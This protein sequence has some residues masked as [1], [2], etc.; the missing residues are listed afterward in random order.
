[1]PRIDGWLSVVRDAVLGLLLV[2]V[3]WLTAAPADAA[4]RG[5]QL[6]FAAVS[7][8]AVLLRRRWPASAVAAALAA[9]CAAWALGMTY[10]PFVLAGWCVLVL[11]EQRGTRAVPWWMVASGAVLLVVTLALGADGIEDRLRGALLGAV[12]L[13]AAW[14]LGV[15][16]REAL[17]EAAERSRSEERLRLAR[18]VHDVLSHS[19]GA[20]G[21]RAGVTAHVATL[22]EEDLRGA[23]RE[24]EQDARSSLAELKSLLTRERSSDAGITSRLPGMEDTSAATVSAPFEDILADLARSAERAGIRVALQVPPGADGLPADV[25]TTLQRVAQEALTNVVRHA[26]ASSVEITLTLLPELVQ[27]EV[28]DDGRGADGRVVREGHGLTGIRERVALMGGVVSVGAAGRRFAVAV[29]MPLSP[30]DAR[31]Q[32]AS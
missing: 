6:L 3:L 29:S 31:G 30:A 16:T 24:I 32:K 5:V 23:L 15:R 10:D 14:V 9:T 12:V 27:L 26:S 11:A 18:D 21:V 7:L 13:S 25:R 4:L 22:G 28:R 2:A 1:M 8:V 20:I 19:L 17:D